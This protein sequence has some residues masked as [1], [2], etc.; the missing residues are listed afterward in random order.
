MVQEWNEPFAWRRETTE[1]VHRWAAFVALASPV[2]GIALLALA[3][4]AV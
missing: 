2:I 1:R 4:G 3:L